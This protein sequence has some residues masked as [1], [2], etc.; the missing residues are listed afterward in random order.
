MTTLAIIVIG[1]V[2]LV[3]L[4]QKQVEKFSMI[5]EKDTNIT[6]STLRTFSGIDAAQCEQEC[7]NN[8]ACFGATV[9]SDGKCWLKSSANKLVSD[10]FTSTLRFP[11]EMYDKIEFDGK[12]IGLDIGKYTLTDLQTKGY[13]EK[14]ALS[15]K[16]RNG[17]KVTIFDKDAFGGNS[18]SFK[19]NQPDLGMIVKDE[20]TE[21]T[22]KWSGSVSSVI[23]EA[24]Y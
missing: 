10:S 7:K 6:D 22:L 19:T 18:I 3:I 14:S 1:L 23:V 9:G 2:I 17:Y 20:R 24:L 5:M 11:C 21:P 4:Q 13:N 8:P 15:I 12:G 16:I